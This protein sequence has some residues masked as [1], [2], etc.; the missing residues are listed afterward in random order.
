MITR[1]KLNQM[2]YELGT[3]NDEGGMAAYCRRGLAIASGEVELYE[4]RG[5]ESLA[6]NW[7]GIR[8]RWRARL[9]TAER[10]A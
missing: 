1:S 5:D 10:G 2:A 8:D 7:R 6:K 9:R 4:A 3:P